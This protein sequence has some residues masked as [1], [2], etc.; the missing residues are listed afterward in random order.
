M[1]RMYVKYPT[2]SGTEETLS[3]CVS[4]SLD[5]VIW[6]TL[7]DQVIHIAGMTVL[8]SL[9]CKPSLSLVAQEELALSV[10]SSAH[11]LIWLLDTHPFRLA[12][13]HVVTWLSEL[14][15]AFCH[16]ESHILN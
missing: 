1:E 6:L 7:H 13:G 11:L 10:Q 4:P 8:L 5:A 15:R 3:E 9:S 12:D 2:V 14:L 16:R